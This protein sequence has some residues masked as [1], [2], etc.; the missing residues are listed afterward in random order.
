MLLCITIPLNRKVSANALPGNTC[1][2][3]ENKKRM[4]ITH[5]LVAAFI[6]VAVPLSA[7]DKPN[8]VVVL[9]DDMG[10]SD[11]GCYGSGTEILPATYYL[12]YKIKG[13]FL[14]T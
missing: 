7:I 1:D 5:F 6:F 12:Q 2:L 9:A 8:I 14:H 11:L 4:K 3:E 10:F 13:H